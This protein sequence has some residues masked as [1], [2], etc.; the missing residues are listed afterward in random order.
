MT[1]KSTP[2][3]YD[4]MGGYRFSRTNDF[5]CP[6]ITL[7]SKDLASDAGTA[8]RQ[9]D[10][11]GNQEQHYRD[12]EDDLGDFDGGS[13]DA[14]EAQNACDQG[15]DQERNDPAEHDTDLCFHFLFNV[16]ATK[17]AAHRLQDQSGFG[18][19]VPGGSGRL[20]CEKYG[21]R[22]NKIRAKC[23]RDKTCQIR[24]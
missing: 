6:E 15:D 22:R 19:N 5:V 16:S 10:H 24:R 20:V 17:N 18:T 14:A 7:Q 23:A 8:P 13:G 9:T 12:E 4:T 2:L 21:F 1:R 11:G 3:G